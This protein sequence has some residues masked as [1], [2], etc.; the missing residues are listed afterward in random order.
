MF[1]PYVMKIINYGEKQYR[2]SI[3]FEC[4]NSQLAIARQCRL[5]GVERSELYYKPV[6]KVDDTVMISHYNC[7]RSHQSLGALVPAEVF[8]GAKKVS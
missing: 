3:T 7:E 6:P 5:L 4:Q 1:N 2:T 8:K